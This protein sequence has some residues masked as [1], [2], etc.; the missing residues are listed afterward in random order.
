MLQLG[1]T[2]PEEA[3]RWI[4]S[5]QGAALKVFNLFL[6]D[7]MSMMDLFMMR[8]SYLS[9]LSEERKSSKGVRGFSQ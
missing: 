6:L 5:L 3:A 7:R 8:A 2:S 1:A 4:R 9:F